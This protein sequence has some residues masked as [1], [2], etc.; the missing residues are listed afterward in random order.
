MTGSAGH[1]KDL[2][3]PAGHWEELAAGAMILRGFARDHEAEMAAAIEQVTAAAPF[4]H[5][6]T[7]GGHRMSAAMSNC[8]EFGWT[9]D[10]RGYR[11]TR[12]DPET[13]H[14][15]PAMPDVFRNIAV[16]AAEAASFPGF[17]P[18]ACLIN[19]YQP[20]ARMGLHQD[21]NE[22]DFD[23]PI[24]SVS[25]GLPATFLFGGERRADRSL[26]LPLEHGD[27]VV[28]G[29]AA[30]LRYHGIA[31]LRSGSHPFAGEAR[32]NLTLRRAQ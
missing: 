8:G 24:V 26:R 11:Y 15:W 27:V 14:P 19:R 5:M 22:R 31:P 9:T 32:L 3:A 23:A 4:R 2:F 29:A 13:G 6:Q 28:W 1:T 10:R 18:D 21:R 30:R 7:P 17:D 25:L 16:T 20:G 12:E